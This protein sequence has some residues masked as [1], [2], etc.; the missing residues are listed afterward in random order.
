MI[1]E[2]RA[3]VI[4]KATKIARPPHLGIGLECIL[5]SPGTSIAPNLSPSQPAKGVSTRE[6]ISEMMKM[7][8][9][10]IMGQLDC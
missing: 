6:K 2:L 9:M 1:K 7:V 3:R 4:K 8:R 10:I 5:R